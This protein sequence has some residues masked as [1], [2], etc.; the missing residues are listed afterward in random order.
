MNPFKYISYG[1]AVLAALLFHSA[2]VADTAN[3]AD[4]LVVTS[5]TSVSLGYQSFSLRDEPGRAAEY[6][7]FSSSPTLGLTTFNDTA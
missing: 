6:R 1:T 7:S 5:E 2:A 4:E 3:I